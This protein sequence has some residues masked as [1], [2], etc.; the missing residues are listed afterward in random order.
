M[1]LSNTEKAMLG[2]FTVLPAESKELS[3]KAAGK[4]FATVLCGCEPGETALQKSGIQVVGIAY[5]SCYSI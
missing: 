3:L 5:Y 4:D 2:I 1:G